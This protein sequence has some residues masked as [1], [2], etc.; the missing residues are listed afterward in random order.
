M[1]AARRRLIISK[2]SGSIAQ[3]FSEAG[4]R[5]RS[6]IEPAR[7][8]RCALGERFADS[9]GVLEAVAGTR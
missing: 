9:G 6:E 1:Y 7:A 8:G 3:F 4:Q 2:T 5:E